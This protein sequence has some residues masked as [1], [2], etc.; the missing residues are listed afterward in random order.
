MIGLLV[1]LSGCTSSI[2]SGGAH[3]VKVVPAEEVKKCKSLG[4]VMGYSGFYGVFGGAAM[5]SARDSALQKAAS[6]GATHV[7]WTELK[8]DNSSTIAAGYAYNCS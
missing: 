2:G 8:S 6:M 4:D 3:G 7:T 1:A 5:N